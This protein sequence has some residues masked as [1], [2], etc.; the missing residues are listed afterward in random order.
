MILFPHWNNNLKK[1][2]NYHQKFYSYLY[3]LCHNLF[4]TFKITVDDILVGLSSPANPDLVFSPPNSI[5][6]GMEQKLFEEF[7]S[8]GSWKYIYCIYK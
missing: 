5:T 2:E 1:I 8:F 6:A 4:L 7:L 3:D